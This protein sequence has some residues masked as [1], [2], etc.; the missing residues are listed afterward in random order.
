MRGECHP[1][2]QPNAGG[3][4][5]CA[6][7]NVAPKRMRDVFRREKGHEVRLEVIYDIDPSI[8]RTSPNRASSVAGINPAAR[9]TRLTVLSSGSSG[10]R[11]INLRS[12]TVASKSR[13]PRAIAMFT[14]RPG[15]RLHDILSSVLEKKLL[16][17]R[18][19]CISLPRRG[20]R[21]EKRRVRRAGF[22]GSMLERTRRAIS[23]GRRG[24]RLSREDALW[25]S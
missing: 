8:L 18:K 1:E 2:G 24:H 16:P 3:D 14:S 6:E 15:T 22:N 12:L 19:G 4:P 11:Q 25:P 23:S 13:S 5:R 17:S 10:I 21:R 20:A 9:Q 7:I